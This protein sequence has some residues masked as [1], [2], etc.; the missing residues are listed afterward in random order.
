MGDNKP[1]REWHEKNTDTKD[2]GRNKLETQWYAPSSLV[3]ELTSTADVV[4]SV[5]NPE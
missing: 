5:I 4:R 2:Y 1:G 3:L